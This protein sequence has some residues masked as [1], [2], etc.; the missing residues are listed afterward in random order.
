[1]INAYPHFLT[2]NDLFSVLSIISMIA[3]IALNDSVGKQGGIP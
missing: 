2:E 3:I 1:M